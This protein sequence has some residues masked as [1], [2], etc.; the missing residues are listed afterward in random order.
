MEQG[1]DVVPSDEQVRRRQ[2]AQLVILVL[3][4]AKAS[5]VGNGDDGGL[6]QC[7]PEIAEHPSECRALL[8]SGDAGQHPQARGRGRWLRMSEENIDGEAMASHKSERSDAGNPWKPEAGREIAA[9]EIAFREHACAVAEKPRRDR[10]GE[11]QSDGAPAGSA[12]HG[13]HSHEGHDW[14]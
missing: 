14:T 10:S 4:A 1:C 3:V 11:E 7:A 9:R 6:R 5:E 8:G 2:A 13:G 12:L